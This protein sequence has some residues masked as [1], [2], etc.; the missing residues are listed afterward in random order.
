MTFQLVIQL[1]LVSEYYSEWL[2]QTYEYFFLQW[3][4]L[5]NETGLLLVTLAGR[6]V[7]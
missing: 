6:D 4:H 2:H 1:T 3:G 7:R 5:V